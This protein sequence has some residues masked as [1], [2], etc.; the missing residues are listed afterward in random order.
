MFPLV[1]I[2][3]SFVAREDATSRS[4]AEAEQDEILERGPVVDHEMEELMPLVGMHS[5]YSLPC[6][7]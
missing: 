4:S 1:S 3:T 6:F 5:T 2:T 7:C